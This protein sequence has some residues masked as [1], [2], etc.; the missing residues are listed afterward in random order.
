MKIGDTAYFYLLNNRYLYGKIFD[1]TDKTILIE[2]LNEE[3]K[4]KHIAEI[5]LT[6]ILFIVYPPDYKSEQNEKN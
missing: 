4:M 1:I 5:P 2:L 6:S 3:Y